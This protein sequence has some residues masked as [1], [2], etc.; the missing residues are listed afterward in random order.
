LLN[1]IALTA[2]VHKKFHKISGMNTTAD[3]FIQFISILKK[4]ETNLNIENL[5]LL[6]NWV[7]F[8]KTEIKNQH[9]IF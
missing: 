7:L 6:N 2:D 4:K 8:L 1:G 3:Q 9:N 5:E